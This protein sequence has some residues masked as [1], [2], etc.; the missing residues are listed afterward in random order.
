MDSNKRNFEQELRIENEF[1][2]LKLKNMF[3]IYLNI[4]GVKQVTVRI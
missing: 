4:N 3:K 1:M 2:Q